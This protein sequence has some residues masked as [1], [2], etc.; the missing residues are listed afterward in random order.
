LITCQH[1]HTIAGHKQI[2][3]TADLR[4]NFVPGA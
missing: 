1:L 4:I 3:S 2:P